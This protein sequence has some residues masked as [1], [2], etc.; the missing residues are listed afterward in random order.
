MFPTNVFNTK[1]I[2]GEN[3][4]DWACLVS[5]QARDKLALDVTMLV[6]SFFKEL[7]CKEAS[8]QE[9]VHAFSDLDKNYTVRLYC[10]MISLG[11]SE[12]LM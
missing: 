4:L 5:P 3:K 6:Q 1:V 7:L 12:S 11:K 10:S 8:L 9:A 2:D